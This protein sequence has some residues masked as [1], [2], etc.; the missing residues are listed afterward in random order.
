MCV[1]GT[2]WGHGDP[3]RVLQSRLSRE[4]GRTTNTPGT[5]ERLC[6]RGIVHP[7]RP[8]G[9]MGMVKG[10]GM[11]AGGWG[12]GKEGVLFPDSGGAGVQRQR[13]DPHSSAPSR[14]L[15]TIFTALE[16][17]YPRWFLSSRC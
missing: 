7:G 6:T 12:W 4:G 5:G 14:G 13:A 10:S 9:G 8:R 1:L 16:A 11:A 17:A 15:I 2:G 3:G